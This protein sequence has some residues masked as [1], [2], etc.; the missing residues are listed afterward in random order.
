MRSPVHL[1]RD[2]A[3]DRSIRAAAIDAGTIGVIGLLAV[4]LGIDPPLTPVWAATEG[5]GAVP[6][7]RLVTLIPALAL[8]L[9]KHR[10][11]LLTLGSGAALLAIDQLLGGSIGVLLVFVDLL[12]TATLHVAAP[13]LHVLGWLAV[14]TVVS[15]GVIT[16]VLARDPRATFLAVLV[17]VA[18]V[19]TPWW[20][21]LS[22]RQ[23]RELAQEAQQRAATTDWLA[24]LEY[25]QRLQKERTQTARDLHD[26]LAGNLAAISMNAE[27]GVNATASRPGAREHQTLT[28]IRRSSV[29]ALEEMR[30]MIDVLHTTSTDPPH[31]APPRL[32]D[33]DTLLEVVRASGHEVE[34]QVAGSP[35][36]GPLR[37]RTELTQL[38]TAIDQAAHRIATE[39]LTNAVRHGTGPMTLSIER[40][41]QGITLR[42]VNPTRAP[43]KTRQPP[44]TGVGLTSVREQA[45][46]LGGT[47]RSGPLGD[48]TW[49]LAV[50]LS[51]RE[52]LSP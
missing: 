5:P 26:A 38:P 52:D 50:H 4:M 2:H 45:H 17:A 35:A 22:V 42:V 39:G 47:V 32:A 29:A 34:V 30:A 27:V 21:G 46:A 44:G 16:T 41:Q 23:H 13:A 25:Q 37:A 8:V 51:T 19:A 43:A 36:T 15:A 18:I 40:D 48:D 9:A 28:A 3:A 7:S 10:A 20:W 33:L 31:A 1:W 14:G 11:P 6:W 12:Y 24:A 49:E